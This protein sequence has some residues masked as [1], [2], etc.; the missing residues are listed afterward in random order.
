MIKAGGM[1]CGFIWHAEFMLLEQWVAFCVENC[2]KC[3]LAVF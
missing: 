1:F 3:E 2:T